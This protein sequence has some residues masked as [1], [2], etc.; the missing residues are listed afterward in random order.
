[1]NAAA[2]QAVASDHLVPWTMESGPVRITVQPPPTEPPAWWAPGAPFTGRWIWRVAFLTVQGATTLMEEAVDKACGYAMGWLEASARAY[3][4]DIDG[5]KPRI[6]WFEGRANVSTMTSGPARRPMVANEGATGWS[7]ALQGLEGWEKRD[8]LL[9]TES[10]AREAAVQDAL[11]TV[12]ADIK[13]L[14]VAIMRIELAKEAGG[15]LYE[16]WR[17][18]N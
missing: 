3:Q 9:S 12:Q 16:L 7:Y 4:I 10:L 18:G 11:E 15:D 13:R 8:R 2:A 1:M 17:R 14:N 5:R 6:E